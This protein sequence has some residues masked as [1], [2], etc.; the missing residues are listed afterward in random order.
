VS[1]SHRI[2]ARQ[3]SPVIPNSHSSEID[4][5]DDGVLDNSGPVVSGYNASDG[6]EVNTETTIL[7][8]RS[9][10][11]QQQAQVPNSALVAYPDSDE[12]DEGCKQGSRVQSE[13]D[14]DLLETCGSPPTQLLNRPV[15]S[16]QASVSSQVS[17]GQANKIFSQARLQRRLA[18]EPFTIYQDQEERTISLAARA[19]TELVARESDHPKENYQGMSDEDTV[20]QISG[21]FESTQETSTSRNASAMVDSNPNF[22]ANSNFVPVNDPRPMPVETTAAQENL[23]SSLNTSRSLE[24]VEDKIATR[25]TAEST[26]PSYLSGSKAVPNLRSSNSVSEDESTRLSPHPGP[27]SFVQRPTALDHVNGLLNVSPTQSTPVVQSQANES[28]LGSTPT[29]P[30]GVINVDEPVD[31]LIAQHALSTPTNTASITA[32]VVSEGQLGERRPTSPH[33]HSLL[34]DASEEVT[35]HSSAPLGPSIFGNPDDIGEH[36]ENALHHALLSQAPN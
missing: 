23:S 27:R 9:G 34:A 33:Q 16:S 26:E 31:R 30:G 13:T 1:H 7:V 10:G 20:S 21:L 17:V 2:D 36:F 25:M 8:N 32:E 29:P 22:M 12:D 28:S 3:F 11:S 18:R 6:P 5:E 24:T 15:Q 14:G 19:V 4:S 35:I